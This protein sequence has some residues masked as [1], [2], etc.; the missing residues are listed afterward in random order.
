[1]GSYE[2]TGVSPL[3]YL[4]V[5]FR[6]KELFIIPAFAGL[7]IGICAG[8]VLPKKFRSST[9]ILVEEG[10]TD[11]PLFQHL[12]VST[13]VRQRMVGIKESIL[14][15]N[16]MIELIKRLNLDRDVKDRKDFEKLIGRLR[17]NIIIR[18]RGSNIIELAFVGEEPQVTQQI[19]KNITDIFVTR[20]VEIQNLETA[21]AIK[22][23]EEQ[24]KVYEGKI[25]SAEIAQ[26]QDQLNTLLVD[27][28]EKHP[29]VRRIRE[30]VDAKKKELE[31][32]NLSFTE[33]DILS[34]QTT[35]PII[36]EIKK[37][38]DSIDT[39]GTKAPKAAAINPE[40][41]APVGSEYYKVM[42]LEKLDNVMARDIQVNSQ[43]Y[44]M[45]LNR[46]ETAKITQR[47]QSSKEGTRYTILD[48]P[49]V[50]L[51]PFQPNKPLIA[52]IGLFF[53]AMIGAG[54]VLAAEFLDKSFIDVEEAKDFLGVPLLGA[55]S[56]I[57]TLDSIR[58]ERE[59]ERW[60]YSLTLVAGI[61]IVIVTLT[62]SKLI[63]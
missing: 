42:L 53:G 63:Q 62:V 55:I 40:T 47:L 35:N 56:K 27:S 6:R 46:L 25:K 1:M 44:N 28:T 7:V 48:P 16:S 23:I 19:V 51:A 5:F 41:G 33:S 57:N 38:L 18:L 43:I 31:E 30:Q 50:P 20:N 15:W 8:I 22:F 49:R 10:K 58:M 12:A 34:T 60:I 3:G 37:A 13:T 9:V 45:L 26:L 61:V 11:N 39:T 4:K 59:R 17:E 14:G 21:D 32:K 24:L 54:L 36:D 52:F 2:D 29:S